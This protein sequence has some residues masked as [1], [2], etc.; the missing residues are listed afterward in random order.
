MI[1]EIRSLIDNYLVWLKDKTVLRQ[2][3]DWVEIYNSRS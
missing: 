3:K 2:V 1:E